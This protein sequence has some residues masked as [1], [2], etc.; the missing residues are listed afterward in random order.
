MIY[1]IPNV[2]NCNISFIAIHINFTNKR[3]I[4]KAA[5]SS[6]LVYLRKEKS[7]LILS[8]LVN[9]ECRRVIRS[10]SDEYGYTLDTK[11]NKIFNKS[12]LLLKC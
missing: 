10:A 6:D 9:S 11:N 3:F 2:Y 5:A 12:K 1:T 8:I 7:R 4:Y